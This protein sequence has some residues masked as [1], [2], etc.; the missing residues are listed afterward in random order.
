MIEGLHFHASL[1]LG[2]R[3]DYNQSAFEAARYLSVLA[4][5]EH[6]VREREDVQE[7]LHAKLDLALLWLARSL[8]GPN[9][10]ACPASIGLET[11]R[12]SDGQALEP[13]KQGAVVLNL[14]TDLPFLLQLPAYVRSCQAVDGRWQID[15]DLQI[16]DEALRDG[17]E[18]TV[19]RRHRRMIQQERGGQA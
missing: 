14:S 18:R 16:T 17:W 12:W 13:G 19:F 4:S 5:F 15:V 3:D 6:T 9:P 2:W 7:E 1:P 11:M 8:A 10:A